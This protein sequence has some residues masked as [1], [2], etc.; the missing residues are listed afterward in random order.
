[1]VAIAVYLGIQS[2]CATAE[3]K[4]CVTKICMDTATG[5]YSSFTRW[6]RYPSHARILPSPSSS[7]SL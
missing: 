1:M 2:D 5:Y 4:S 7:W 6:L 3:S